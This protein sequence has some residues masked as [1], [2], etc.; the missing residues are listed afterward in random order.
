[1]DTV[2]SRVTIKPT[3]VLLVITSIAAFA[4]GLVYTVTK[5]PIKRQ[6]AIIEQ[7]AMSKIFPE[8]TEIKEITT[9]SP[10]VSP[11]LD[12]VVS[13]H[14]GGDLIG[15]GMFVAP[16]GYGG[17]IE[18]LV[19]IDATGNVS[20]AQILSHSETPGLGAKAQEPAFIEQFI[21]VNSDNAS[22]FKLDAISGATITSKAVMNGVM[23]CLDEYGAVQK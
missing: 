8:L 3:V 12:R 21:G 13:V 1:M 14:N 15:Y 9:L 7:N 20:G 4:L 18:M 11:I 10:D 2:S 17:A 6:A 23:T 5:E 16:K 19:G 22:A